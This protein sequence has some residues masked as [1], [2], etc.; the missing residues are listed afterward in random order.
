MM[1]ITEYKNI[2][3]FRFSFFESNSSLE[4]KKITIPSKTLSF[5]EF[6]NFSLYDE[7]LMKNLEILRTNKDNLVVNKIKGNLPFIT[8]YG[9]FNYRNNKSISSYNRLIALD[10]DNLENEKTAKKVKEKL[11]NLE[12][13]FYCSLSPRLRGIKALLSLESNYDC[14]DQ[15]KQLKYCFT[16]WFAEKIGIDSNHIDKQQFVLCQPLFFTNDNEVYYSKSVKPLSEVN[17]NYEAPKFT[18]YE[19][20][21]DLSKISDFNIKRVSKYILKALDN[22]ILSLNPNTNRH[23]Q[24]KKITAISCLLHYS[25]SISDTVKTKW[26][27]AIFDLYGSDHKGKNILNSVNDAFQTGLENPKYYKKIDNILKNG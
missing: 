27:N 14:Q 4:S 26:T 8:P 10:I 11:I 1:E 20:E 6:I 21:Y 16:D 17:F 25:P 23:C 9:E 2:T 13:V 7:K 18:P 3:D 12:Y 22:L 15:F 24:I 5:D 19:C